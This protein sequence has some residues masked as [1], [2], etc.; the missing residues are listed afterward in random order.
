MVV[1][2]EVDGEEV[3]VGIVSVGEWGVEDVVVVE[4]VVVVG[5]V[6]IF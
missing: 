2:V 6:V 3:V 4:L 5:V 1:I